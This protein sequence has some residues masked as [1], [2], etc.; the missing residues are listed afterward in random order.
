MYQFHQAAMEFYRSRY[1][2][3]YPLP[4]C[5]DWQQVFIGFNN[6]LCTALLRGLIF[7]GLMAQE[8]ISHDSHCKITCYIFRFSYT[9]TTTIICTKARILV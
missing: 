7:Q 1:G 6:K 5:E 9:V 3:N 8:L 2:L 4:Y